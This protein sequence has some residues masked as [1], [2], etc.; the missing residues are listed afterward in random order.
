MENFGMYKRIEV[1]RENE[2]VKFV[3]HRNGMCLVYFPILLMNFKNKRIT[4]TKFYLKKLN[5]EV[6]KLLGRTV[7]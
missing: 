7:R 6:Y 2:N 1:I 3:S 5:S 4:Q